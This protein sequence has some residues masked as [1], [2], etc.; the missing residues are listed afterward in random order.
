MFNKKI[1]CA[2]SLGRKLIRENGVLI[3][4]HELKK[5]YGFGFFIVSSGYATGIDAHQVRETWLVIS[6]Q[7]RLS[8]GRDEYDVLPGSIF[9]F[10]PFQKH[11]LF[12]SKSQAITVFNI[13][14]H[15][16]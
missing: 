5:R 2:I 13:W 9:A 14:W 4:E 7:G 3:I 10:S 8:R 16:D 6:G 15:D 1:L 12:A 11:Q